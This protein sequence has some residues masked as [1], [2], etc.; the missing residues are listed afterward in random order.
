MFVCLPQHLLAGRKDV[1]VRR[2]AAQG[3]NDAVD[4]V[5]QML[6]VVQHKQ[7]PL[8]GERLHCQIERSAFIGNHESDRAGYCGCN[9]RRIG[10]GGQLDEHPLAEPIAHVVGDRFGEPGLAD[11][12][13]SDDGD[14]RELLDQAAQRAKFLRASVQRAQLGACGRSDGLG[15]RSLRKRLQRVDPHRQS[16]ILDSLQ[17]AV[18]EIAVE[19]SSEFAVHL[20]RNANSAGFRQRLEPRGHIDAITED[21]HHR[22][23]SHVLQR[24]RTVVVLGTEPPSREL[25][26]RAPARGPARGDGCRGWRRSPP[27]AE[28]SCG[29][30]AR[31]GA[32][33]PA[34]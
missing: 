4:H 3:R 20:G 2:A 17:P 30:R 10:E 14:E 12:R 21:I 16:D 22:D 18:L 11:A 29:R 25:R 5:Q 26:G 13:G 1:H 33:A 15:G 19:L 24:Y 32:T 7:E 8:A 28:S 34:A 23:P 27:A 9:E 31:R 6:A